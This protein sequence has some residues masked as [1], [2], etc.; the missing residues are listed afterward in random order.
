VG[1]RAEVVGVPA[2]VDVRAEAVDVTTIRVTHAN[3][4]SLGGK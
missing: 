3:L 1:V 4:G 2:V